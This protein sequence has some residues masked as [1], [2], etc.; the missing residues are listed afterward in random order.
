MSK[1]QQNV[2]KLDIHLLDTIHTALT[3]GL[4]R[5]RIRRRSVKLDFWRG[6]LVAEESVT[7]IEPNDARQ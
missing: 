1:Q 2:Q 7:T 3:Q 6:S 5:L 4:N